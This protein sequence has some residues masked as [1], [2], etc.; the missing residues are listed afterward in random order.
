MAA[1]ATTAG[2]L[3]SGRAVK[4][5]SLGISDEPGPVI[6]LGLVQTPEPVAAGMGSRADVKV[7]ERTDRITPRAIF[8]PF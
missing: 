6:L 1:S 2:T 3:L 5:P 8:T 7:I 4:A